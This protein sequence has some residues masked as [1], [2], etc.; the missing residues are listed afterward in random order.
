MESEI[1]EKRPIYRDGELIGYW[2]YTTGIFSTGLLSF[3]G[4]E[5]VK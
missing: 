3:Y 2:L 4:Y 5:W 1:K